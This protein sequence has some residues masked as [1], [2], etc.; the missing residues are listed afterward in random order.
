MKQGVRWW[1]SQIV[2]AGAAGLWAGLGGGAVGVA[3]SFAACA[4]QA[5][6]EVLAA[7]KDGDYGLAEEQQGRL[8]A[9]ALRVEGELGVAGIKYGCD[10]NGYY[11]GLARL[12]RLP[13]TGA[14]R[15]EVEGLMQGLHS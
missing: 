5:C 9:A 1:G 13:L 4:P 6:Y 8:R 12:P 11:G 7:W 14:E 15:S 2:E 10:L 3:P